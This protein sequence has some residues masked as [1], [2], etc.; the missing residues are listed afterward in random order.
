MRIIRDKIS[1]DEL[2]Q[3]SAKMFGNLVKAV[4][5][6]EEAIMAVDADMHADQEKLLLENGSVQKNLWGI[7]LYPEFFS[8]DEFIE[9]DSMINLRSWQNNRSR[10]VEDEN[11]RKKI[12]EVVD[13]LVKN[14]EL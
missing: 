4:V 12:V 14:N 10:G 6:I 2:K 7:N 13:K 9:F 11:I 8:Q 3:M 1:I 5:D